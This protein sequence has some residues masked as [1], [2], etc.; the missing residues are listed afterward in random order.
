[1]RFSV[2]RHTLPTPSIRGSHWDL[3][4][5]FAD[6]LSEDERSLYCFELHFPPDQ[7]SVLAASQLPNHRAV[8]LHYSGPI[9]HGRGSVELVLGG[10]IHWLSKCENCYEFEL[11]PDSHPIPLNWNAHGQRFQ[12]SRQDKEEW[13]LY[14]CKGQPSG[15]GG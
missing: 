11:I 14:L 13:S 4:L 7:W 10:N 2:L 1:M 3:L 8:Y 9:S 12:L 6:Y 5:Q 15:Q